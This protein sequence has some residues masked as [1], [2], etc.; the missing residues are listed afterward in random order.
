VK[1]T[2]NMDD[3]VRM[4]IDPKVIRDIELQKLIAELTT[5]LKN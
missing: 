3:I 2:F 5:R 4:S 1:P